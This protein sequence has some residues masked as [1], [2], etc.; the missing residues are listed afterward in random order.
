MSGR[1]GFD[2]ELQSTERTAAQARDSFLNLRESPVTSTVTHE[3]KVPASSN[4]VD[5]KSK[6]KRAIIMKNKQKLRYRYSKFHNEVE[7]RIHPKNATQELLSIE[8]NEPVLHTINPKTPLNSIPKRLDKYGFILNMDA[9]GNV[10]PD[11]TDDEDIPSFAATKENERKERQWEKMMQTWT[12]T[13]RRRKLLSRHLR[14]G[15]PDSL[16]GSVWILLGNVRR[17]IEEASLSYDDHVR[18]T[19]ESTGDM[20]VKVPRMRSES[21]VNSASF[22]VTQETIERDIHR[23]YPRHNMFHE[24][25]ISDNDDDHDHDDND[26]DEDIV[27]GSVD[28]DEVDCLLQALDSPRKNEINRKNFHIATGGQAALR[29]VLRAYSDVGYCQGMNFIAGMFLTFMTEE[30]AFWLLVCE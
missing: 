28:D 20:V 13:K 6:T 19:L 10:Y 21:L 3:T 1:S 27:F 30:E 11:S 17:K 23:T 24:D 29:R 7:D 26:D 8:E 25:A 9:N 15:I 5:G 4:E 14:E 16:R 12:Y 22:M 2:I 18:K